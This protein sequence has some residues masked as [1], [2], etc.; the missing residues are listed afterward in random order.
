V[1]KSD[2]TA[3]GAAYLAGLG[4]C[5]WKEFAELKSLEKDFNEFAPQNDPIK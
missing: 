1:S 5:F 3:T 2:M 4:V